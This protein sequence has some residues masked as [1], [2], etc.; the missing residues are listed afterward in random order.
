MKPFLVERIVDDQKIYCLRKA[1]TKEQVARMFEQPVKIIELL[2]PP[3][4]RGTLH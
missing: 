3:S 4:F 2:P 1:E